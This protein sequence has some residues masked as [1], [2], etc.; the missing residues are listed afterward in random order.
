M[1]NNCICVEGSLGREGKDMIAVGSCD[2]CNNKRK[3]QMGT[4]GMYY[5]PRLLGGT[6]TPFLGR[7]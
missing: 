1:L 6:L 7:G 2:Q 3:N 5:Q 4:S